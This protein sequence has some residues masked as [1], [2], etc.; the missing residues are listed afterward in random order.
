MGG[1]SYEIRQSTMSKPAQ[2]NQEIVKSNCI[3][4]LFVFVCKSPVL[5][6]AAAGSLYQVSIFQCT[7]QFASS[8]SE[9]AIPAELPSA[10]FA[11][12]GIKSLRTL[13][14]FFDIFCCMQ[15]MN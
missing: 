10:V 13:L 7:K 6:A 15:Y 8:D 5:Y 12:R 1:T 11:W 3:V 4:I 2:P 9:F 14:L